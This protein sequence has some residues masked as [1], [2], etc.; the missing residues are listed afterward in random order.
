MQKLLAILVIIAI[1]VF[2]FLYVYE[3]GMSLYSVVTQDEGSIVRVGN[4]PVRV[5]VAD[6]D[7]L[8]GRGL[9]GRDS[10]GAT[11]GMLFIF[12]K[13]DYHRFWMKDM[14]ILIDIIWIAKDLRVVDITKNVSPDTYPHTFEP[15]VPVR[16]VLE[17]NANYAES[18]GIAIGDV[19]TFPEELIP[20]DLRTKE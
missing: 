15:S 19:V 14:R 1:P 9:G 3:N 13:S 7:T 16:F 4:V 10:L 12:D 5:E 20:A 2:Y 11:N 6:T 8:R 18:F 17:T